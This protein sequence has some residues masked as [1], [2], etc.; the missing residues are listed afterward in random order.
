MTPA[1][2]PK[3]PPERNGTKGKTVPTNADP[4]QELFGK[5]ALDA[6]KDL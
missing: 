2:N 6:E 1:C 4:E 3:Q 5:T